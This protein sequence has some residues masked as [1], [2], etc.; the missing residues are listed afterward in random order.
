MT[1]ETKLATEPAKSPTTAVGA[2][3]PAPRPEVGSL[4]ECDSRDG[5]HVKAMVADHTKA[6]EREGRIIYNCPVC[7]S[8]DS[9]LPADLGFAFH[10]HSCKGWIIVLN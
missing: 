2:S 3:E 8:T 1:K 5:Q 9:I 6:T 7:K 10:H 4:V